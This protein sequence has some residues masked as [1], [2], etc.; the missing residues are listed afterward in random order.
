MIYLGTESGLYRLTLGAPW[1]VFH[2]LQGLRVRTV[3]AGG[4]GRL[5]VVDERG[6]ILETS[7][8]GDSWAKIDLPVGVTDSTAYTMGGSPATMLLASRP[9]GLYCRAHG[10][11]WWAKL[12]SPVAG[13]GTDATINALAVTGGVSAAL[14][15]AV[16]GDG[17]YRSAD[18]AKTWAKV[19][20]APATIHT[21]RSVGD[22]V[23]LGTDQGVFLSTDAGATFAQAA[24]GLETV[25]QV[26]C[27]DINP[28]DPKWMLAGAAAAVP[29]ATKAAVRPQGFQ[30]GLYETKDAGKTWAK[31]LK[32]GLPELIAFDTISDIRFDPSDP[33]CILM[34]QGSGECWLTNNGGDY[35]VVISRGIESAR[36]VAATA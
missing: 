36:S 28:K 20:S 27:L 33:D 24:K 17:L 16:A 9:L 30:F 5:T 8:N 14:L 35:W 12:A 3:L 15:A 29:V 34:A 19:A 10:S 4:E 13:E 7:N 25:P 1:P 31:V 32:K 21:I 22:Q 18:G 6:Q 23:A 2:S 26:H 11:R